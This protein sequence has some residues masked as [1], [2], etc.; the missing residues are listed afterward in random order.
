MIS[1]ILL[2]DYYFLDRNKYDFE[3]LVNVFP[4]SKNDNSYRVNLENLKK[5]SKY[6]SKFYADLYPIF[7]KISNKNLGYQNDECNIVF[8]Q[9]VIK[10]SNIF[11]DHLIRV[12]HILNSKNFKYQVQRVDEIDISSSHSIFHNFNSS[13]QLNQMMIMK[14]S[15]VFGIK[16]VDYV[17][18]IDFPELKSISK[19]KNLLFAPYGS[20]LINLNRRL[21][22]IYI[23]IS[24]FLGRVINKK[25]N[26]LSAGFSSDEFYFAKKGAY[27]PFGFMNRIGDL[28]PKI[29]YKY[30]KL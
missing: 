24:K 23:I 19:V 4:M 8:N 13:W 18:K 14:I 1:K 21:A 9:I 20:F 3:K 28:K 10:L 16:N 17:N 30:K 22:T 11:F 7:K 26:I 27:G 6:Q 25:N 29:I 12:N 2:A 5:R 15:N